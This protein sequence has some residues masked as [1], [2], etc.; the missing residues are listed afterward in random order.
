IRFIDWKSSAR[1]GRLLTKQYL[2]ERNRTVMVLLDVSASNQFGAQ[3]QLMAQIAALLVAVAHYGKDRVGLSLFADEVVKY[4]APN[5][6]LMHL[7]GLYQD[8]FAADESVS[9]NH[10]DGMVRYASATSLKNALDFLAQRASRERWL[11]FIISDFIT[12]DDYYRPLQLIA[13]Q[14]DVIALRC[15]DP[16][17]QQLPAL[18]LLTLTDL[19]TGT[20]CEVTPAQYEQLNQ[21]LAQR[22][23][24]QTQQ[25]RQ[26]GIALLELVSQSQVVADL[27]QLFQQRALY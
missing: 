25:L 19:E 20:V 4:I 3:Y 14:H 11:L 9:A 16:Q 7:M 10:K 26:S 5:Q 23:Q 12:P 22:L 27:S 17:A 1:T 13:Q 2:D 21:L 6:G 8:I 18:G 15:L 24:T